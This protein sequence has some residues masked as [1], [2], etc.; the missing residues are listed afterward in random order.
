MACGA[1][2]ASPLLDATTSCCFDI[3][4]S[5]W[6]KLEK[7]FSEDCLGGRPES[8]EA[9]S[10][11]TRQSSAQKTYFQVLCVNLWL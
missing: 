2:E 4:V 10:V 5:R 7:H 11:L 1:G 6:Y 9:S 3:H 8:S